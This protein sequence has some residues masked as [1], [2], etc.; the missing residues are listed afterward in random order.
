MELEE[1][2]NSDDIEV[3]LLAANILRKE[4]GKSYTA[5]LVRKHDKYEFKKGIGLT[6]KNNKYGNIFSMFNNFKFI[7]TPLLYNMT[8]LDS[9][10]VYK[11]EDDC[12]FTFEIPNKL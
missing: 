6:K 11:V 7:N 9:N 12:S 10:I 8:K 1:M 3:A 5:N 4:K 2:L